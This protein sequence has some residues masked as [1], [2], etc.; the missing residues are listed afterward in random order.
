MWWSGVAD[1]LDYKRKNDKAI[2]IPP[3]FLPVTKVSSV[4]VY[5]TKIWRKLQIL[6]I[7]DTR[8]LIEKHC[9]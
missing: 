9:L 6:R 5:V 4:R 8:A 1:M 2:I 3:D 7:P